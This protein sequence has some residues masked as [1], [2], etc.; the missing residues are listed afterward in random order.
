MHPGKQL[1][2]CAEFSTQTPPRPAVFVPQVA[3]DV[4]DSEH[5]SPVHSPE[6]QSAFAVQG[7]PTAARLL[8]G[9]WQALTGNP[10]TAVQVQFGQAT[11]VPGVTQSAGVAQSWRDPSGVDGHTVALS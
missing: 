7:S 6:L 2:V 4:Q 11:P 1:S 3:L 5:H 8:P 9:A 10:A